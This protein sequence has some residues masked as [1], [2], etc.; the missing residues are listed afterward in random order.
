LALS[1]SFF[2]ALDLLQPI[3]GRYPAAIVGGLPVLDSHLRWPGCELFLI[4]PR[5]TLQIG[6]VARNLFGARLASDRVV[7][8][9]IKASLRRP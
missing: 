1:D 4:G 7:P 9:L 2:F 3:L 6:P 8:A 5:A